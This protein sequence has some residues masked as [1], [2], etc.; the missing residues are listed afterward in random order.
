MMQQKTHAFLISAWLFIPHAYHPISKQTLDKLLILN[1]TVTDF[2]LC[3]AP[4][5]G[6]G[7][8]KVHPRTGC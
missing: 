2:Q 3:E 6:K 7:K 8:G 4:R 1:N 5:K